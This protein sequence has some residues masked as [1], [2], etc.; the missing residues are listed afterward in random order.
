MI[1]LNV[2]AKNLTTAAAFRN[3]ESRSWS[4]FL[5]DQ[6]I[7]CLMA[8]GSLDVQTTAKLRRSEEKRKKKK[9][10]DNS[11]ADA[12][13]PSTSKTSEERQLTPQNKQMRLSLPCLASACDRYMVSDRSAAAIA[14]AVLEDVGLISSED[15]TQVIDRNKIR[16][17]RSTT[18]ENQKPQQVEITSLYFDG[19]KDKTMEVNGSKIRIVNEEHIPLIQEPKSNYLGHCTTSKGTSKALQQA[20]V[21]YCQ[22]NNIFMDKLQ[23]LGCDGTLINR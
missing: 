3:S 15:L 1:L 22:E 18:R 17:A 12:P 19:R 6:R 9:D 20:I 16:R 7:A 4:L 5:E 8:I 21:A 23:A 11:S 10:P 2:N 13:T 14:S